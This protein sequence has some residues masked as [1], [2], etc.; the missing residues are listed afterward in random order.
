MWRTAGAVR[1]RFEASSWRLLQLSLALER[2]L[3]LFHERAPAFGIVLALETVE[4]E[5]PAHLHVD[6]RVGLEHLADDALAGLDGERRAARDRLR[7]FGEQRRQAFHPGH[8][9]E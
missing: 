5:L 9:I 7:I 1:R 6:V 8:A 4:D 3:S 2:G